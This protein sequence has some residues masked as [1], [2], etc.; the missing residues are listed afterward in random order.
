[1]FSNEDEKITTNKIDDG[2][3]SP[4]SESHKEDQSSSELQNEEPDIWKSKISVNWSDEDEKHESEQLNK[5]T[6][7]NTYEQ[8]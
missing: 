6:S 7:Q 4:S 2:W 3:I 1:M 8:E 5:L